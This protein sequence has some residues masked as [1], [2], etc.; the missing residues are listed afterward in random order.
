M[1]EYKRSRRSFL[2]GVGAAA[3]ALPCFRL[4][5]RSAIGDPGTPP[6]RFAAIVHEHGRAIEFWRP[7]DGFNISYKNSSLQPFDDVAMFGRSLREKLLVIEGLDMLPEIGHNKEPALLS[8][9][10]LHVTHQAYTSPECETIDQFLAVAN[11]F[12]SQTAFSSLYYSRSF[13]L[14][15]G[16]G[17]VEM[18]PHLSP[19]DM[20]NEV[21]GRFTAPAQNV[22]AALAKGK[23]SLDYINGSLKRLQSRLAAPERVVLDQHLTALRQIERRLTSSAVSCALPEAPNPALMPVGLENLDRGTLFNR[24][25]LDIVGEAFACDLTRFAVVCLQVPGEPDDPAEQISATEQDPGVARF[26]LRDVHQYVAHEY[27]QSYK[28]AHFGGRGRFN[29][30]FGVPSR[31]RQIRLARLTKYYMQHVAGFAARLDERGL[32]DSSIVVTA[33]DFGDPGVHEC[34]S[35]PVVMLGGGNG[36]FKRG[37][38]VKLPGSALDEWDR[39]GFK[40]SPGNFMPINRLW[41]SVAQAFGV[42]TETFGMTD[43]PALMRGALTQIHAS[44]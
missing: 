10:R 33:S 23:S 20:Y 5:Q 6:L 3:L 25:A 16:K 24:L 21:F 42:Q 12:G 28:F 36:F 1:S 19:L 37:Q 39:M 18:N 4:L 31:D 13:R 40:K 17:G 27:D 9:S 8:G 43:D 15:F 22:T 11:Q 14:V 35:L 26:D 44:A 34:M 2:K 30:S 38:H 41:V 32:L 7:G 29:D